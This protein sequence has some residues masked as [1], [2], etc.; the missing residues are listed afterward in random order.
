M[1]EALQKSNC[2]LDVATA[3]QALAG[4]AQKS[5]TISAWVAHGPAERPYSSGL[6]PRAVEENRSSP[7]NLFS[8][9]FLK[10]TESSL[11]ADG[12]QP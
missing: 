10:L 6:K 11:Y 2:G 7:A 1:D 8:S 5:T 12:S 9:H 3:S 4:C